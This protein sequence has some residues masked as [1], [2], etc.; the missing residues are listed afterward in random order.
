MIPEM[1]T[2]RIQMTKRSS[3]IGANPRPEIMSTVRRRAG[4]EIFGE[5]DQPPSE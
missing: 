4:P 5:R 3:V 2:P 1:G